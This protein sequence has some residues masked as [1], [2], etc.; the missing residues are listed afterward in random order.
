MHDD[1][2]GLEDSPD[3]Y[4]GKLV[5]VF[6][7]IKRVL[8]DDGTL[9]LI[10]GD[11]YFSNSRHVTVCDTSDKEPEDYQYRGCLCENLCGVCRE[12]YQNRKFHNSDLLVSIF[13]CCP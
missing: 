10:L 8:Q 7:E 11:S 12:V 2:I 6:R 4:V 1:Q 5:K 13:G 3:E 9:F